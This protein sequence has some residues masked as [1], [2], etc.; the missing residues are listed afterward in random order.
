MFSDSDPSHLVASNISFKDQLKALKDPKVL[1]YCQ[2]YSIVFGGY[3]GLSLWMVQY[4][5]GE[6]GLEIRTAALLAACFSLPGGVLRAIGGWMSD[7]YG[8]HQVTWWVMWVS[9]ICLFLLS[10][11]QTDFTIQTINGP[12]TFH[13]GLNIYL[14]TTLMFILGI[15]WA[16]GK[17]SVFKYI[18]DDYPEN[19]GAI[20]GIVGLAGGLGGFILPIMFGAILDITGIRSSAFMLMYGVVWVSLIW[21]YLTEVRK[22]EVM[23]AKSIPSLS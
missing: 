6:F 15:A 4:Y 5:V 1:R 13:I 2:Y 16:F 21:M 14:F 17:A 7:K 20:S 10:Y 3:V 12:E 8:A 9:W 22:S 18:G 23:G 11:P 19:I